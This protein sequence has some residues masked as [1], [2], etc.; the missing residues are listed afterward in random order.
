MNNKTSRPIRR[1]A[2]IVTSVMLLVIVSL[3]GCQKK[4]TNS[5][6]SME[7]MTQTKKDTSVNLRQALELLERLDEY[8][9]ASAQE[10]IL[11]NMRYW[12][13]D[14]PLPDWI[15][16]PMANRLPKEYQPLTDP[17][18]LT[19]MEL[20]PFDIQMIQEAH[21]LR[22]IGRSILI[23]HVVPP[24]LAATIQASS[25]NL[26]AETA[27]DVE[28]ACRLFDW[29]V[30]HIQ[31]DTPDRYPS[32]LNLFVWE[33]LL[34]G[35]GTVDEKGRT[36]LLLARQM[37]LQ[38]VMLG[39][40]RSEGTADPEAWLPALILNDQ[41]F[42]FDMHLGVPLP[43]AA[44]DPSIVTWQE[45]RQDRS[46]LENL[47]VGETAYR[48]KAADLDHVV[49]MIDAT[50]AYLSQRMKTIELAMT[51]DSRLVLSTQPTPIA[52]NL[53]Q[54]HPGLQRMEIWT[55]PYR[56]F[57]QRSNLDFQSETFAMLTNEQSLFGYDRSFELQDGFS[58]QSVRKSREEA[59]LEAM[60]EKKID[61]KTRTKNRVS[62]IQGR[63]LQFRGEYERENDKRGARV[64]YLG[65][66][67]PQS[68]IDAFAQHARAA[69]Q[70]ANRIQYIVDSFVRTKENATYWLG[71][72]NFDEGDFTIAAEYFQKRVL[73]GFPNGFWNAGAT[74][75]LARTYEAISRRDNNAELKSQAIELYLSESNSAGSLA[76]QWRAKVLQ[77]H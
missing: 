20:E 13:K 74:Y 2:I 34:R 56:A 58:T 65:C 57:L 63:L 37:G 67:M 54:N 5:S 1:T 75:N 32:E 47:S 39:I 70:P 53:Q 21:W 24:D 36:F 26:D 27:T 11:F 15:A 50:P 9:T 6:G 45:L 25:T 41:L 29:V 3:V 64:H 55:F 44:N 51:G 59:A 68:E 46:I 52:R 8:E 12:L 40:D 4:R 60:G 77:Q 7:V 69:N 43:H 48:L 35:H 23:K 42:L 76:S 49:A 28:S 73:D 22:S 14:Q 18:I 72:M 33:V 30:R 31:T 38:V 62:L 66:R 71:L 10:R 16:D 19:Q 17:T 61:E